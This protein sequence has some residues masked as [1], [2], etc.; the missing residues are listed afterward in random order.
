MSKLQ[1]LADEAKLKQKKLDDE[2]LKTKN[3]NAPIEI[4]RRLREAK[5]ELETLKPYLK[6]MRRLPLW[7][8]LQKSLKKKT[9]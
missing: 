7:D 9:A 3:D 2:A 4:E 1:T 5:A 8:E 6:T